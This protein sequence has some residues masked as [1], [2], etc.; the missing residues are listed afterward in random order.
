MSKDFY[1]VSLKILLKNNKIGRLFYIRYFRGLKDVFRKL[2]RSGLMTD[3][4][5]G[6]LGLD[7][8]KLL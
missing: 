8:L 1:Q 2:L 7:Y 5:V 3:V 6:Y 4:E